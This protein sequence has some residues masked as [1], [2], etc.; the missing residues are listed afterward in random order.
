MQEVQLSQR[1][2]ATHLATLHASLKDHAKSQIPLRYLIA[3]RLEAGRRPAANR[4]LAYHLA[5]ASRSATS[6]GPVCD[7]IA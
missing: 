1:D 4:N 6:F 3:D 7:E 5:R 2:R